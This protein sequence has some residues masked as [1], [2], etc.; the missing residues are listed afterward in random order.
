MAATGLNFNSTDRN[1]NI[2]SPNLNPIQPNNSEDML[3]DSKDQDSFLP[4]IHRAHR[5]NQ[6]E[7]EEI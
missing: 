1:V 6:F 7:I 5:E 3:M 2:Q 4:S